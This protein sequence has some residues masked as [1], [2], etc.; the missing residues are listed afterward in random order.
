M[1]KSL[2]IVSSFDQRNALGVVSPSIVSSDI[3]V[4]TDNV[5]PHPLK[6]VHKVAD[7]ER[8]VFHALKNVSGVS[9]GGINPKLSKTFG[10]R[11]EPMSAAAEVW[12]QEKLF[13]AHIPN[14]PED[15]S[16]GLC[17]G[18]KEAIDR[19]VDEESQKGQTPL[20]ESV[21]KK[22]SKAFCHEAKRVLTQ[23]FANEIQEQDLTG[24]D[25]L[26]RFQMTKHEG[27][28]YIAQ[29]YGSR[30]HDSLDEGQW[31]E[32]SECCTMHDTKGCKDEAISLCVC[33]RDTFCC[34]NFWDARCVRAVNAFECGKCPELEKS[35]EE[36]D[37]GAG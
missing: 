33:E 30:A 7:C 17:Q 15:V 9:Y 35:S 26:K 28:K 4:T 29:F 8:D 2:F 18:L 27:E 32:M 13:G 3:E 12:C 31:D 11:E 19:F 24:S 1:H 5:P 36:A 23:I 22:A 34:Q 25:L 10:Y 16:I 20:D 21:T 6:F 14:L 37:E